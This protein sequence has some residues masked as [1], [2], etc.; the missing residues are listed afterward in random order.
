MERQ[1]QLDRELTRAVQLAIDAGELAKKTDARQMAFELVASCS[2]AIAS[3]C[4]AV[5][6]RATSSPATL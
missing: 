5:K 1:H 4:F 6:T 2:P 3:R